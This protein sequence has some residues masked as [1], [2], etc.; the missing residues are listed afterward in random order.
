MTVFCLF[1]G[2]FFIHIDVDKQ[3]LGFLLRTKSATT[4]FSRN[5][6]IQSSL[7]EKDMRNKFQEI[8]EHLYITGYQGGSAWSEITTLFIPRDFP[9]LAYKVEGASSYLFLRATVQVHGPFRTPLQ[10]ERLC[11]IRQ[12]S[13]EHRIEHEKTALGQFFSSC[14]SSFHIYI[15]IDSFKVRA[16]FLT[17]RRIQFITL[18]IY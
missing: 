12:Y 14:S 11:S 3:T 10:E 18:R 13:S 7:H 17:R 4:R 5:F 16:I 9:K 15:Y 8:G 2:V 1:H 6:G